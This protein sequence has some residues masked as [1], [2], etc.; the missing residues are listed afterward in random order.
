MNSRAVNRERHLE[1]FTLRGFNADAR[2]VDCVMSSDARDAYG[3]R[4]SQGDWRLER[5]LSNPIVLWGHDSKSLPIGKAERVR[6]EGG[7][8]QCTIRFASAAANPMAEACL[9][10][11]KEGVL[12]GVS[13]GF[14]PGEVRYQSE[15][16]VDVALLMNCELVELSVVG[17]PANADALMRAK[18]LGAA[19]APVAAL[20]VDA[21]EDLAHLALAAIYSPPTTT[22][23]TTD[24][25]ELALDQARRD[26]ND[27]PEGDLASL[28]LSKEQV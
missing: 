15:G 10:L 1:C 2:T 23:T 18:S 13:V 21:P 16:G 26:A 7:K 9:Q 22:T 12:R 28:L 24:L 27:Q 6:V 19:D 11:V 8:L 20:V 25:A 17:I 5:Y 4:V 3:E 14:L